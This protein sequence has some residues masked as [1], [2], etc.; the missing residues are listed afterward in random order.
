MKR[1]PRGIQAGFTMVEVAIVMVII[2]LLIGGI[3][4]GQAMIQNA[5]SM[6]VIK[7]ADELRAAIMAFYDKY[8]VFPGDESKDAIPPGTDTE[9]D[10]DGQIEYSE[11]YEMF[12][13]L[14]LAGL[15]GGSFNGSSDLPT[16]SFGD[17]VTLYW[18]DPGPGSYK[19]YFRFYNLPAEVCLEIDMKLDDGVY[20][21]GSIAGS[22]DYTAGSTVS[23]LY[24]LF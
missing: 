13:D 3:L 1:K 22:G 17:N 7:Q 19:H 2:G 20:N 4:K 14:Q 23:S 24:I 11:Q 8:G 21:T 5:K 9:G 12:R 6:R 18:L 10:N 15:I 16:H